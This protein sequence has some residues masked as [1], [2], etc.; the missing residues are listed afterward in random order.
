VRCTVAV[1]ARD[2]V[3]QPPRARGRLIPGV[4]ETVSRRPAH[5][6]PRATAD[7]GAA[8]PPEAAARSAD[9]RALRGRAGAT[10]SGGRPPMGAHCPVFVRWCPRGE[11]TASGGLCSRSPWTRSQSL[12]S[13]GSQP[14]NN[15]GPPSPA[16]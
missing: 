1:G 6:L 12:H 4:E 7:P 2:A 9:L 14:V 16:T 15:Q 11:P 10:P 5:V 8:D 3:A 13:A